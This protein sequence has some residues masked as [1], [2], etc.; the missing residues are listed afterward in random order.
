MSRDRIA[1]AREVM[2][3]WAKGDF[4]GTAHLVSDEVESI[5]GEPPSQ[6]IVVCH[7]RVEVARRFGEFLANWTHFRVVA[8]E[9]IQL[10]DDH[11]L[12]VA[13]Q[14]GTGAASGVN[15]EAR[16]HLV[17]KFAGD[18]I[19]GTYWFFDREKSMR[20]AGLPAGSAKS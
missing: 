17:F 18:Q 13:K 19:V 7:G 11:V 2:D 12:V 4:R 8:D 6:D 10:D 5:W 16:V 1:V 20:L 9:L 15:I 14:R 3:H